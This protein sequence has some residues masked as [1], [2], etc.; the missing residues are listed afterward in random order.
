MSRTSSGPTARSIVDEVL[1]RGMT[2]AIWT[3]NFDKVLPLSVQDFDLTAVLP[4]VFYMFRFGHR[5]GKGRFLEA[6]G[7]EGTASEKKK[8]ATIDRVASVLA[9]HEPFTGF[10]NP[11]EKAILGDLLLSFCV[12]NRSRALG[13]QEQVIRVAP[14]HYMASWVDLPQSVA[15]LRFVPEMLV[16]MLADQDGD[17]VDQNKDGDKTWFAVGQGFEDN[18]LLKVFHKGVMRDGPLGDRTSDRFEESADVGIDQLLM[19]RL[20]QQLGQAPDKLRGKESGGDRISNQRPISE[21]AARHFSEDLRHFIRGYADAIPRHSFVEMLEACMAVGLTTIFSS[22]VELLFEWVETGTIR[23]KNAQAP[24]DLFVDCSNG[25][26]RSLR[27]VAEQSMDDFMR[28]IERLPVVLMAL[29]LLDYQARYDL[30]LKKL[31]IKYR[32]YATEWINL[33]G[34]LLMGRRDEARDV[35][36]DLERIAQRLADAFEDDYSDAAE[37]LRSDRNQ[38][39]P[40]WR[41]AE[42]L[43]FLQGRKSAQNNVSSVLD[44]SLLLS[45]PNGMAS[46]RRVMRTVVGSGRKTRDVRSVVMTDAV[47]DHLVHLHVLRTGK[48]GGYRPLA[49]AEFLSILRKRHGLCIDFAPPGVTVSNDLLRENRSILERRLRDLGLLVGVNDAESMK[50]LRPR[51]EPTQGDDQ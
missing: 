31:D 43:T 50:Y 46:K 33:L 15:N 16:A 4:A 51:F 30:S 13:R 1:G 47:L 7:G 23:P 22:V 3:A 48:A 49:F 28:R 36:R 44:S 18:L 9:E 20:A 6:F 45:R 10:N 29:R 17:R 32:P 2:K 21:R 37:I 41:I 25:V 19:I 24:A 39:S 11:V 34:D 27:A 26:Q 5:R 12:E 14:A 38:P 35:Q 40:V 8:A 42:T